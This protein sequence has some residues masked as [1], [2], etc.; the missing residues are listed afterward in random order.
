MS[1]IIYDYLNSILVMNYYKQ[2]SNLN[3]ILIT[4]MTFQPKS[5]MNRVRR[6]MNGLVDV[7]WPIK[8]QIRSYS[9]EREKPN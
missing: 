2:M 9:S 3:K 5:I 6:F 4:Q 1:H 8:N 7:H